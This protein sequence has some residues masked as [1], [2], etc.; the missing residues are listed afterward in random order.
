VWGVE[1]AAT[2]RDDA[3]VPQDSLAAVSVRPRLRK[4][5]LMAPGIS[6]TRP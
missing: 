5:W 2:Q 4:T 1:N 3:A 6:V